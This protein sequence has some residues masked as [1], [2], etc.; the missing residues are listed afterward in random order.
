M[1][2]LIAEDD[3][4][5]RRMLEAMLVKWGYEVVVACDGVEAWRVLQG[6]HAPR[7]AILDWMMPGMDGIQLCHEIRKQ[8]GDPYAYVLLLSGNSDKQNVIAGLDAGADDYITKPFDAQ[9]LKVRL[10][11]GQRILDLQHELISAREALL[12]RATHDPLTGL[13]N[14]AAILEVLSKELARARREAASIAVGMADLDRFKHIN[15]TYGHLAGDAVLREVA[16][17]LHASIRPYDG[18]GRYGGEEFL[19]VLPGCDGPH[20]VTLAERLRTCVGQ[21][22]IKT[23]EGARFVTVS[24]AVA[25]ASRGTEADADALLHAADTA[26]YQAKNR[27]RNRVELAPPLSITEG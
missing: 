7:L 9:E 21:E 13:W 10:R 27:G 1:Q 19:I 12:H 17:R 2:V 8:G 5:Y 14:R 24:I 3:P 22:P 18:I 4:I 6:T 26:L 11:T 16:Q 25:M 23:P 20:A 15:D